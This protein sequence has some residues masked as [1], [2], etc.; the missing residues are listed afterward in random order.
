V[1]LLYGDGAAGFSLMEMDTFARHGLGV[2]A[3]V[4]NDAG[5]TQIARDQVEILGDDVATGLAPMAY[6]QVGEGCGGRGIYVDKPEGV[7][8]ALAEAVRVSREGTPVVLNAR[9]TPTDFR[10]GS[11]SM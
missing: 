5:W 11:L 1:W 4:G 2:I 10:K 8:Q 9:I 6:H 3:V 7:E